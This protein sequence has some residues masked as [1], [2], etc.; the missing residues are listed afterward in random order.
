M[1]KFDS[2]NYDFNPDSK[3]GI[4]LIHGFSGTTYELKILARALKKGGH[5]VVLNN[6]PG[7]GTTVEDC[8]K[9]T[10]HDWLNYSKMELAKLVSTS[11][12]VF[13][14]GCSMGAVIAL[15]L[16][17]LFPINGVIVGAP[18][19]KFKL[20]FSTNYLNTIFC[21]LLKKRD[22]KLTF[23][24]EIRD[25]IQFY[26]YDYYPLIALNEFRKM[27]KMVLKK[28][29]GIK[30]PTL[31][32]HSIKDKVSIRE[33]VD[34]IKSKINSEHSEFLNLKH[35]HHNLFDTN[36]ETKIINDRVLAFI[37]NYQ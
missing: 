14:V 29:E 24:K 32:M 16:A 5:H 25:T 17:S 36:Q 10:Y 20:S 30:S 37:E 21:R 1:K 3:T 13:I 9:Y 31:I 33:N 35:A 26:G 34:I 8:N 2:N 6:L 7:H 15:Y 11:D 23:P 19:I 28:L 12:S 27:N 18:V 22:K 4:Y